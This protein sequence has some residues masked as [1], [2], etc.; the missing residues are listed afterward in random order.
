MI[1]AMPEEYEIR[2][3]LLV[4]KSEVKGMLLTEFDY[5][6]EIELLKKSYLDWGE[7]KG[8]KKGRQEEREEAIAELLT[9]MSAEEIC[10]NFTRYSPEEI[11]A[12]RDKLRAGA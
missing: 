6:H 1:A 10:R 4:N 2:H 8:M 3:Y 12:V 9:I 11:Y 7:E 5:D